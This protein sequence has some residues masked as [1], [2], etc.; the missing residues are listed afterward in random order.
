MLNEGTANHAMKDEP[1]NNNGRKAA[2]VRSL[3]LAALTFSV[4]CSLLTVSV[5]V[6]KGGA[7]MQQVQ[8]NTEDIRDIK[9]GG[10]PTLKETIKALSLEIEAR[11]DSDGLMH[12]RVDDLRMDFI[13]RM[14]AITELLQ[15]QIKQQTELIALIRTQN[16]VKGIQ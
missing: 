12:K 2:L 16:G 10:S 8:Q 5:V 7:L 9:T 3:E 6:F 4:I 11:K 13:E 14:K 1:L 15:L